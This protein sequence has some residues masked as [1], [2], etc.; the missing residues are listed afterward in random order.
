MMLTPGTRGENSYGYDPR[1]G[2]QAPAEDVAEISPDC[3]LVGTSQ[4]R[5]A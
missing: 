3:A 5:A 4:L 1:G 2:D